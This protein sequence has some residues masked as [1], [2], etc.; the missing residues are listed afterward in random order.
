MAGVS[1][2][3][4]LS[5]CSKEVLY[6]TDV[7]MGTRLLSDDVE[8]KNEVRSGERHQ[9]IVSSTS[10]IFSTSSKASSTSKDSE[11]SFLVF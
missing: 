8:Y 3:C 11:A 2:N 6:Y 4:T 7:P 9:L 1:P 5:R 10:S